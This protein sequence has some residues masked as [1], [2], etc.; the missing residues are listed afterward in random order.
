MRDDGV[1]EAL[2]EHIALAERV[3]EELADGIAE[4]AGLVLETLKG[5][6]KLLLCGNGGSAADAQHIAAEFVVRIAAEREALP[7]VALSANPSVLT[8]GGNDLGFDAV[9]ARQVYALGRPGDLLVLHSTSGQSRNLL[10]AAAAAREKGM[11]SAALLARDGGEL[12][13]RVDLALVVPTE[14]TARAQEMHLTIAHI[15]CEHVDRAYAR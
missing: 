9:F 15:V 10:K 8:A 4:Y 14:S 7:A 2:L 11:R 3:C 6:G 5:G 12:R 1:R 13:G